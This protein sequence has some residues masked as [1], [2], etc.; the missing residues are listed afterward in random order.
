MPEILYSE[1]KVSKQI[2][3]WA[4]LSAEL[5]KKKTQGTSLVVPWLRL[6]ASNAGY[7]GSIPGWGNRIPH[8]VQCGQKEKK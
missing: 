7:L 3:L 5:S 4:K 8:A 1:A 2:V 6:R